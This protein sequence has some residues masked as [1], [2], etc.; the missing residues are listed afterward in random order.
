FIVY[1]VH[2][3]KPELNFR[4]VE[5]VR[6]NVSQEVT[7]TGKVKKGEKIDLSFKMAGKIEKIWVKEG[8]KVKEG[9]ILA[10]LDNKEL[11][12]QLKEAKA[13]LELYQA[14]LDKLLAGPTEEEIQLAQTKVENAKTSLESAKQSL[15]DV[16]SQAAESLS[17]AYEDALNVLDA[18]LLKAVTSQNTVDEI[19]REY[20]T[21]SDQESN[22]V[23]KQRNAIKNAVSEANTYLNIAKE[24]SNYEDIDAAL[25]EMREALSSIYEALKIIRETCDSLSYKNLISST[26]KTTLDNQKSYINTALGNVINAQQAIS[27]TKIN[28]EANIN[29]AEAEVSSA[30][31]V[32][33]IAEDELSLLI[34]P[35]R[36]E[37][38]EL[39]EAQVKQ[40]QA[41]VSLLEKQIE[42]TILKSPVD[43]EIIKIHKKEGEQVLS[44]VKDTV[45]SLLPDETYEVEV[46]IYEEDIV[47]VKISDPVK[48]SLVAFPD[49]IFKGK[50]IEID[51]AEK[52]I[53]GVVYYEV[54]IGFEETPENIKP[55]M[56]ADIA[57]QTARKENVLLIPKESLQEKD[58]KTIVQV[59][60]NGEIKE[61][62]IE[63]GLL[64]DEVVEI[65]SGLNEGEKVII[66]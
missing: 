15:E 48:I 5:V 12:I 61:K 8:E 19:E 62:E 45:I 24:T 25:L 57:I 44:M 34:S 46:D 63:T 14:K 30:K 35:P 11:K 66:K 32:L 7:E 59:F 54:T 17:S 6:G 58:D 10:K 21:I 56:T 29:T 22:K 13:S 50:V 42:D 39:Y 52:L 40:A 43:G 41:K 9:D 16:K 1:Q 53:E 4:I 65:I 3:R 60:E 64:G 23:K 33:K 38:I 26:D 20:F 36:K 18:A 27:Q 31:G 37:D 55:G 28:N 47:K 51:P 49:K 2:F